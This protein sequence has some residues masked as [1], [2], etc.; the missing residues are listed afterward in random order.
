MNIGDIGHVELCLEPWLCIFKMTEKH[1]YA[2]ELVHH[3]TNIHFHYPPEL[4]LV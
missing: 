3:I 4:K 2:A 1:K